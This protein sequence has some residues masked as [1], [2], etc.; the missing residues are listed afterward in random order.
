MQELTQRA[1]PPFVFGGSNVGGWARGYEAYQSFAYIG[2][3]GVEPAVQALIQ[4]NER[5]RKFGFTAGELDRA[6]DVGQ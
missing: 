2:Q 1:D 5:A 4:E 6:E 3:R